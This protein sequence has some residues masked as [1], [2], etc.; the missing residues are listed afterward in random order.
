MKFL[1]LILLLSGCSTT[2]PPPKPHQY[3]DNTKIYKR[4]MI[5]SVDGQHGEGILVVEKKPTH[6]FIVTSRG[7]LD[8]FT[9]ETCHREWTKER[10]WN[11]EV[12]SGIF[13]WG[14]TIS[15][16]KI[17]F[18]F[19]Q[20]DLEKGDCIMELGGYEAK[21][22]RHS[23]ALIDFQDEID[24]LPAKIFCNGQLI[25]SKGVSICQSKQGLLQKIEFE[26]ETLMESSVNCRMKKNQGKEFEF[27]TKKDRCMYHF[28]DTKTERTHRLTTFGYEGILI[29]N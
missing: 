13:G 8:M 25:E 5:L 10:S 23:W 24:T 29:R 14:R 7:Q 4:D 20:T 9:L 11:V 15:Q 26:N 6:N 18:N 21:G 1:L 2:K 17:Q 19:I 22:G 28:L 3:L 12:P 16:D 27:L